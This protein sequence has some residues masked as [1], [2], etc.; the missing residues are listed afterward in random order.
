[1]N[2]IQ[3]YPQKAFVL[4]EERDI[5]SNNY[6]TGQNVIGI[7]RQVQTKCCGRTDETIRFGQRDWGRIYGGNDI[8]TTPGG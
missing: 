4:I 6:N 1:M 7:L 8:E 3:F 2:L 5:G